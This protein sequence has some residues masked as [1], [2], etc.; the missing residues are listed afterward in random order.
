MIELTEE[1]R[2]KRMIKDLDKGFKAE[3]VFENS[4]DKY[5]EMFFQFSQEKEKR[6]RKK[7]SQ[8][9]SGTLL[10]TKRG[11]GSQGQKKKIWVQIAKYTVRNGFQGQ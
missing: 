1:L 11:R 7:Q 8:E 6:K 4:L 2:T 9:R 5:K 10:Y 3:K